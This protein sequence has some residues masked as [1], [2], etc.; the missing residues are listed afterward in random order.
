MLGAGQSATRPWQARKQGDGG[1]RPQAARDGTLGMVR[2]FCCFSRRP[3]GWVTST[4]VHNPRR[5]LRPSGVPTKDW[6][7]SSSGGTR[8][9]WEN[10]DGQQRQGGRRRVS[11][12]VGDRNKQEKCVRRRRSSYLRRTTR[13]WLGEHAPQTFGWLCCLPE[14][15]AWLVLVE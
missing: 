14:S 12:C 8:L 4:T 1:C 13:H 5:V 3:V 9:G 10:V 2:N 11:L 6:I 15:C 7:R